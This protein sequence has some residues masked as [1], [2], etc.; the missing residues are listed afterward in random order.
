MTISLYSGTPGSG[1]SLHA[2]E[3]IRARLKR[4]LPVVANFNLDKSKIPNPELFHYVDNAELTPK[5]LVDVARGWFGTHRFA[6]DT[7]LVVIDECQ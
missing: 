3:R 6:E 5:V 4:G 2:T 7:V 1:K